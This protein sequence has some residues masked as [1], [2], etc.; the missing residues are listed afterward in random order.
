MIVPTPAQCEEGLLASMVK[1]INFT[2]FIKTATTTIS[3][4]LCFDVMIDANKIR[5]FFFPYKKGK[6]KKKKP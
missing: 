3:K 6:K 1:Y 2:D 5:F 4:F